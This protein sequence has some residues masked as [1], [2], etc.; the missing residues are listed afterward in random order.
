MSL[1]RREGLAYGEI[2]TW[3][4]KKKAVEGER[5]EVALVLDG[6]SVKMT[7]VVETVYGRVVRT[8]R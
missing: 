7:Y 6:E 2:V 1:I 3:L 5:Y 4:P 8:E